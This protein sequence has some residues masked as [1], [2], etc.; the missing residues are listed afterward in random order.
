VPLPL[1]VTSVKKNKIKK[2]HANN[3][4]ICET[5]HV[6]QKRDFFFEIATIGSKLDGSNLFAHATLVPSYESN[7]G[8]A[9]ATCQVVIF[10][11]I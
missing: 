2:I 8:E 10:T 7:V 11:L 5:S 3:C 6:N 9:L 4:P 1:T